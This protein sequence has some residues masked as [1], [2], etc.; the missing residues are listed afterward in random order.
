MSDSLTQIQDLINDLANFMCNSI[1]VLQSVAPPCPIS[2][3]TED[4]Q[5]EE[6]SQIFASGIARI[7]KDIEILAESLPFDDNDSRAAAEKKLFEL[8]KLRAESLDDLEKVAS[9]GDAM[10]KKITSRLNDIAQVQLIAR[11]SC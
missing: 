2:E 8:D 1:G 6:Q 5:K 11:P 7:A 10:V 9:L 4:L 3:I